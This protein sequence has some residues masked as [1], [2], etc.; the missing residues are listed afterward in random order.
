MSLK[1]RKFTRE[2]LPRITQQRIKNKQVSETELAQLD[3]HLDRQTARYAIVAMDGSTPI[4]AEE[5][6]ERLMRHHAK[7]DSEVL[8]SLRNLM[9]LTPEQ[10]DRVL[11]AF[12][13]FSSLVNEFDAP[14]ADKPK[15]AKK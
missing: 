4:I 2:D 9:T 5:L 1:G 11:D 14:P 3:A 8:K 6:D 15:K 7:G 12:D 10:R 13:N